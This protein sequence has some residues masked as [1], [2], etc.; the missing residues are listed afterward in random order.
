MIVD[1]DGEIISDLDEIAEFLSD[2]I[3]FMTNEEL[4]EEHEKTK[5]VKSI[6]SEE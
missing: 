1:K 2:N 5:N 4:I 3:T 6:R